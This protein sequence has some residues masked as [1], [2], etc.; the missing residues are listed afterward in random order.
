MS[1]FLF[2]CN[3]FLY[4]STLISDV[5]IIT[6][7]TEP[8][9]REN[10][11]KILSSF[12]LIQSKL[13]RAKYQNFVKSFGTNIGFYFS[14]YPD[15]TKMYI[16]STFHKSIVFWLYCAKYWFVKCHLTSRSTSVN[17]LTLTKFHKNIL[18]GTAV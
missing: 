15:L 7:S 3:K 9:S 16:N 10:T 6:P 13:D 18:S 5:T 11:S 14:I 8:F 12:S 17:F 2:W 4:V 1:L